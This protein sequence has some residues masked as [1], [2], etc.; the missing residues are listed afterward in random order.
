MLFAA[1]SG[2]RFSRF[3]FWEPLGRERLHLPRPAKVVTLPSHEE[4]ADWIFTFH[5]LLVVAD[6]VARANS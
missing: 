2:N 6:H 3:A 1:E 5:H 4:S